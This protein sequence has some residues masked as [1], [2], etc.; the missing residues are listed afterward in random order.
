MRGARTSFSTHHRSRLPICRGAV[1]I[2]LREPDR[3][4][5]DLPQAGVQDLDCREEAKELNAEG[6][7]HLG[8]ITIAHLD[9][10]QRI[11]GYLSGLVARV[12]SNIT[13]QLELIEAHLLVDPFAARAALAPN[14]VAEI[15]SAESVDHQDAFPGAPRAASEQL[16]APICSGRPSHRPIVVPRLALRVSAEAQHCHPR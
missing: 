15:R 5:F 2:G 10:N 1:T 9:G 14:A 16:P 8:R 6:S 11:G 13:E 3:Q 7:G 4:T 12:I